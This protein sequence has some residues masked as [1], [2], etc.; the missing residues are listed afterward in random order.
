MR[1][2]RYDRIKRGLDLGIAL[3]LLV[4]TLPVQAGVAAAVR[5]KH[6]SPVL[7]RQLRPGRDTAPFELLKFRTMRP[8]RDGESIADDGLRL[9][10]LGRF[11]RSSSLDELPS[12]V[13]VLRGDMSLVGPRPL[14]IEYLDRYSPRQAR[15]HEVRP[16]VTG[17]AQISGRNA[18]TWQDKL[19]LDVQYVETRGLRLDVRILGATVSAVFRRSGVSAHGEATTTEFQGAGSDA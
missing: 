18:I 4:L 17:L 5:W 13:N 6:G 14:L 1:Q 10:P 16:G 11:L 8:L 12:L 15:R 19:E 7:F 2:R 3:P 9:T